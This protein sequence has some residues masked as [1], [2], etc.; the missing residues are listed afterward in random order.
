MRDIGFET[1]SVIWC[2]VVP[3]AIQIHRYYMTYAHLKEGWNPQLK[4]LIFID[5][6]LFDFTAALWLHVVVS[7]AFWLA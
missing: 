7:V 4:S 2:Q 3:Y 6:L 5:I 1:L